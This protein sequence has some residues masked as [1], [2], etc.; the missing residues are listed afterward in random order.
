LQYQA[1]IT[2][3][4]Y[5]PW[6]NFSGMWGQSAGSTT[7]EFSMLYSPEATGSWVQAGL[8]NTSG[9]YNYSMVNN[10]SDI[11]SAYAVAGWKND[12]VNLYA[13]IK[14]TVISGSVSVTIPTSVDADGTMNYSNATNKI[15]NRNTGFV[16]ASVDYAPKR[17]HAVSL[18]A[19]YGQDGAGR[20]G[21]NYKLAL[22]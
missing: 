22:Q 2:R 14:P 12:I 11:Q 6:V 18:S 13:G 4:D 16:G 5:N 19:I 17:N 9:K 21:V 20:I 10:V 1:T 15:R 7:A 3:A 8:M